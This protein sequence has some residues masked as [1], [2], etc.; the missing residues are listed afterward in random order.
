MK[1]NFIAIGVICLVIAAALIWLA[2]PKAEQLPEDWMFVVNG[3]AISESD[4][5][6]QYNALTP[7]QKQFITINDVAQ[8]VF[9]RLL[10]LQEARNQG[11]A[12]TQEEYDAGYQSYLSSNSITEEQLL[13]NLELLGQDVETFEATL[14]QEILIT[15]LLDKDVPIVLGNIDGDLVDQAY[16]ESIYK[17]QGIPFTE[18]EEELIQQ[19]QDELREENIRVYVSNLR[20]TADIVV[21]GSS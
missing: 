4:V 14:A 13:Y 21:R 5:L 18:V 9:E 19:V 12:V 17:L 3:V 8:T 20:K 1:R 7:Q 2:I 6:A 10:L 15:K 11:L 16:E